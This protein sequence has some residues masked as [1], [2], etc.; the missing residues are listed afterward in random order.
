MHLYLSINLIS[1]GFFVWDL[2]L[3]VEKSA[4]GATLYRWPLAPLGGRAQS[5][6]RGYPD[7]GVAKVEIELEKW[8]CTKKQSKIK[9]CYA[10]LA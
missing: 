10:W 7:Q 4:I 2:R 5:L 3:V 9:N 8:L 1:M 6:V